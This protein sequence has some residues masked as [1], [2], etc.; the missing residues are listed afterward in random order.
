MVTSPHRYGSSEIMGRTLQGPEPAPSKCFLGGE[1][2]KPTHVPLPARSPLT[3]NPPL[4]DSAVRPG[5]CLLDGCAGRLHL[6][7][8]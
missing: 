5:P 6:R 2:M 1:T 7:G 4:I 3:N 8:N